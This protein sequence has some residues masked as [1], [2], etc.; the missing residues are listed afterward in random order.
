M[1]F[2]ALFL[3]GCLGVEIAVVSINL[4][5]KFREKTPTIQPPVVQQSEIKGS[6]VWVDLKNG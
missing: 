6:D 2:I 5:R 3:G 4:L 1:D